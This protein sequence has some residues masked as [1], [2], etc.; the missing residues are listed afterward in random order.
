LKGVIPAMFLL[1]ATAS[2]IFGIAMG[3]EFDKSPG[4]WAD[5]GSISSSS[6]SSMENKVLSSLQQ[7]FGEAAT[8]ELSAGGSSATERIQY[9]DFGVGIST[10]KLPDPTRIDKRTVDSDSQQPPAEP[11]AINCSQISCCCNGRVGD[12]MSS[13]DANCSSADCSGV[14]CGSLSCEDKQS[15]GINCSETKPTTSQ[16]AGQ[17]ISVL[18]PSGFAIGRGTA[19]SSFK[20]ELRPVMV[21]SSTIAGPG[22]ASFSTAQT[23]SSAANWVMQ[24]RKGGFGGTRI[25]SRTSLAGDFDVQRSVMFHEP[26]S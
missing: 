23:G 16:Q 7:T 14:D 1:M 21:Q 24:S 19:L 12:N 18:I 22:L 20:E 6:S 8:F 15:C 10:A 11:P 4:F 13:I 3:V 25:D 2:V 5:P 17:E 26:P 9:M